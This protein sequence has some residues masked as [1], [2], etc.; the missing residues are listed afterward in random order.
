MGCFYYFLHSGGVDLVIAVLLEGRSRRFFCVDISLCSIGVRVK[1]PLF[2]LLVI[3]FFI[4]SLSMIAMASR[5][6]GTSGRLEIDAVS[7][8]LWRLTLSNVPTISELNYMP[9]PCSQVM[10]LPRNNVD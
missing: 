1:S 9:L 4:N 2:L 5:I 8:F 10:V 7:V 3:F 6:D